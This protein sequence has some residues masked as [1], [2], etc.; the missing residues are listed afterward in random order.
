MASSPTRLGRRGALL[1]AAAALLSVLAMLGPA[2]AFGKFESTFP[3]KVVGHPHPQ[4]GESLECRNGDW[5]PPPSEFAYQWVVGGSELGFKGQ[6]QTI[7]AD[8]LT[9]KKEYENKEIW[10]EVEAVEGGEVSEA[11]VSENSVC[12]GKC[13]GPPPE[14]PVNVTA[15]V[16]SGG[17]SGKA[18]VGETLSCSQGTWKGTAPLAYSYKWF[19]EGSEAIPGASGSQYTVVSEDE[20]HKISCRVTASNVSIGGGEAIK[21][22]SNSLS[23]P[24]TAPVNSKAPSVL[25][26]DAVDEPLTCEPGV[27]SGSPPITY[28]YRWFR[29]GTEIPMETGPTLIVAKNDEGQKLRCKVTAK[30]NLGKAEATSAEV[31]IQK[32]P[33]KAVEPPVVTPES[34]RLGTLLKC[35]EGTWNEP[36]SELKFKYEW[37]REDEPIGGETTDEYRVASGDVRHALY[38]RVYATNAAKEEAQGVSQPI[39]V[40]GTAPP[41]N[42]TL[43][44]VKGT[45][46]VGHTLTCEDGT[47][48]HNPES[49]LY[50]WTRELA[51]I[52]GATSQTYEVKAADAGHG[53]ACR[54]IAVN[55]EGPSEPA[56]SLLKTVKGEAPAPIGVP[57]IEGG[58]PTPHV[59]ESLTCLHGEWTGAPAPT[60]TYAW[61]REGTEKLA[62]TIAY[63]IVSADRGH[64]LSCVVTAS[65]SEAPGGV[66]ASS[67][68]LA[69]P[70][71]LPEPPLAGVQIEGSTEVGYPLTCKTGTWAGVPEPKFT[72]QWLE[73]GTDIPGQASEKLTIGT[74]DRGYRIACRVTGKNVAGSVSAISNAVHVPGEGPVNVEQPFITGGTSVGAPLKCEFGR[75]QGKPPPTFTYQWYRG[76]SPISGAT[77]ETHVVETADS[78]QALSCNVLGT[79]TEGSLEQESDNAVFIPASSIVPL[80]VGGGPVG[81]GTIASIVPNAAEI[82]ASIKRQVG[83]AVSEAHLKKIAKKGSFSFGFTGPGAGTFEVEWFQVVHEA[84]GKSRD[85][86]LGQSRASFA[87]VSTQTVRI[88]LNG[89]GRSLLS[90][91]KSVK[92]SVRAVFTLSGHHPVIWTETFVLHS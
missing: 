18:S 42:Q 7:F 86:V 12:F 29:D 25:G 87:K 19:H 72:F 3:P 30:N 53:V 75:W 41:V 31:T 83:S 11:A 20:S 49:Y 78:G 56:E 4:V 1:V 27:W 6:K 50:Q 2:S 13:N 61:Y 85:R 26:V 71:V 67:A 34:A 23:V 64:T 82:L 9:L 10:C 40:P 22:S 89:A 52:T 54:V 70:G 21:E 55:T 77:E 65:N 14:P 28:E 5:T 46:A 73:N 17:I 33:L 44:E 84:H 63:T 62:S 79:N 47:W 45:A 80:T 58:M 39:P 60:F 68:G 88:K 15:P 91:K 32:E 90:G 74:N 66:P 57:E 81:G 35:S 76:G 43:P 37:L 48:T 16:V 59:G 36:N 92:L 51:P 8:R 38:C 69:V 24:G